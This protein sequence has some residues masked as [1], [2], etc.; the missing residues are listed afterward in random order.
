LNG[1]RNE[2]MEYRYENAV[3]HKQGRSFCGFGRVTTTDNT[4]GRYYTQEYDPYNFSVLKVD[5][6]P[7]A[8]IT[9]TWSVSVQSNK[10]AKVRLSNRSTHDKL[11]TQTVTSAYV[12]DIY[13]NTQKK[14]SITEVELP[15]LWIRPTIILPRVA[16]IC[17]DNP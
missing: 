14:R 13:G 6:S 16:F 11:T 9:N 2:N 5:E 15:L 3:I 8:K 7:T 17:L 1:Q 4:R 10:I 12:Y